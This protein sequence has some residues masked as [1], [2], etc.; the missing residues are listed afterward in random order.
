MVRSH[1]PPMQRAGSP[2][3]GQLHSLL[4]KELAAGWAQGVKWSQIQ[5]VTGRE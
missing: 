3:L 1:L 4:G 5:L 2:W